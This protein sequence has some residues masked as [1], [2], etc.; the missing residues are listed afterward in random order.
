MT[1]RHLALPAT[2]LLATSAALAAEP[3]KAEPAYANPAFANP[4]TPGIMAGTPKPNVPNTADI[5]FIQQL[6]LGGRAEVEQGKIAQQR[7]EVAGVDTFGE[8]MVKDHSAAN[9]KLASIARSANVEIPSGLTAEHQ[10]A[11]MELQKLDGKAFDIRYL[12]GQIKDHQRAATLLI[13]VIGSGQH[14]GA[15]Q[16]AAETLPTVMAHLESAKQLHAELTG[17]APPPP[18]R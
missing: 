9:S 3:P 18:R 17:T 10:A 15:R 5:I 1:R 6:A 11:A 13:H 2:L 4:D 8:H 16:F 7:S 14:D 12:E